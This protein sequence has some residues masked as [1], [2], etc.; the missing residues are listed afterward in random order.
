MESNENKIK[1]FKHQIEGLEKTKGLNKVAY[2]WD[3]GTGK[4][5]M[6]SEKMKELNTQCNLV[7]CQLSKVTDWIKHFTKLYHNYEIFNITDNKELKN[8]INSNP[9]RVGVINYDK[10]FRRNELNKLKDFTLILDE[11]SIIQNEKTSRAKA[12]MKL[13]YK[14]II[15]LSGTPISGKYE[16]LWS[17]SH[18]LGWNISKKLF[19]KQ[20]TI[21]EKMELPNGA[22]ANKIVGYKNV[23]RLKKKLR[24]YGASFMKTEEVID[25]P[26]Q[27]FIEINHS[28]SKKYEIF[29]KDR[30]IEIDNETIVGDM[31]LT[32]MLYQRIL[33]GISDQK[34]LALKDLINSTNRRIVIFYNFK[35]ELE[36]I[37]SIIDRPLSIINGE[38]KDL[39]AYEHYEDSIT[40]VNYQAG[41]KGLNLQKANII[42]YFSPTLSCE[43][44]M[45]SKK[46]IHR[47]GQELPCF[48]YKLIAPNSIEPRIYKALERGE[49]YTNE[50]FIEE[51]I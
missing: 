19:L 12:I 47:I 32:N 18:L 37:K 24:S 26:E 5:F 23:E 38:I 7:V 13:N 46:R 40:I 22:F 25:L 29:R 44:Y 51:E 50:L 10:I 8:F 30:I 16:K 35:K 49:D 33:L 11:S 4:T 31:P 2:F 43:D 3:M 41:A 1:L 34:L 36:K 17:Q 14:N 15:L 20:Y 27:S 28:I 39:S 6:A 48:Y 42:I 9:L 21:T 45:Q